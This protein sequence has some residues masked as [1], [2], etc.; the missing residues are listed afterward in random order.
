MDHI[1]ERAA[2]RVFDRIYSDIG[3]GVLRKLTWLVGLVSIGLLGWLAGKG[4]VPK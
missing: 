3:K 4:I 1:A 2:K